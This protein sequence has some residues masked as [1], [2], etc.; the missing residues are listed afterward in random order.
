MI[1]INENTGNPQVTS[2]YVT[3]NTDYTCTLIVSDSINSKQTN[4]VITVNAGLVSY[5][6]F[7]EGL[8]STAYDSWS[9]NH[10]TLVSGPA[11][12]TD[13]NECISGTCLRFDGSNDYVKID[14]L[15][16]DLSNSF[17]FSGWFYPYSIV[18][19]Q[20]AIL[21][22]HTSAGHNLNMVFLRNTNVS[23]YDDSTK[24]VNASESISKNKWYFLTATIG[25]NGNGVLYLNGK[26]VA[27]F[28]TAV[29][30]ENGG[31]FSI[32]QEWDDATAT[33]F[34]NGLIDEVKIYSE[35]LSESQ[36]K[37]EYFTY[38]AIDNINF[39]NIKSKSADIEFNL[40]RGASTL[41]NISI[42]YATDSLF[43]NSQTINLQNQEEGFITQ[44]LTNLIPETEY[45]V[46][47]KASND[48]G[49]SKTFTSTF[50]SSP[51]ATNITVSNVLTST[52]DVVFDLNTSEVNITLEYADNIE[53]VNSTT[54]TLENQIQGKTTIPLSNLIE[55]ITY[56][57][58][59]NIVDL[60]NYTYSFQNTFTTQTINLSVSNL[61]A[62]V[63]TET[64]L[65]INSLTPEQSYTY[66]WN[67]DGLDLT[68]PDTANPTFISSI[69]DITYN[70]SLSVSDGINNKQVLFVI[71]TTTLINL[72]IDATDYAL[73]HEKTCR[74]GTPTLTNSTTT[75]Y[76]TPDSL[77]MYNKA[78]CNSYPYCGSSSYASQ[79]IHLIPGNYNLNF[80]AR[81][82]ARL[83][84]YCTS[85]GSSNKVYLNDLLLWN[86]SLAGR[87]CTWYTHEWQSVSIPFTISTEDDYDI[88]FF[89]VASDC[90]ESYFWIDDLVISIDI[91]TAEDAHIIEN[92]NIDNT[93]DQHNLFDLNNDQ[94]LDKDVG[95]NYLA[96]TELSDYL[97]SLTTINNISLIILI[98]II[99]F[100]G[101][102]KL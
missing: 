3:E 41:T 42:E 17:T 86:D 95:S 60:E 33:D 77:Q 2:P 4:F 90:A 101:F 62:T 94:S 46:R 73:T 61:T 38:R 12:I 26:S 50:A 54:V 64:T 16:A 39:K 13:E 79:T 91:N 15:A 87:G 66:L 85:Q 58:N 10:G 43:N 98:L 28:T 45:F 51:L 23:Y 29:R 102:I 84:S 81:G 1:L 99:G 49:E 97:A 88:K 68:N 5:W 25:S 78:N 6:P 30:P 37:Q 76:S 31:K 9:Q 8:G 47:I 35:A 24:Y 36:I 70:C 48:Y 27:S 11:W 59:I 53:F 55:N 40:S 83:Y 57:Y 63:D 96:S 44:S 18:T 19:A 93:S 80:Q 74:S 32:G 92:M 21:S 22:F 20:R 67:C 100:I 65:S 69:S 7:N 82:S 72:S 56:Y 52:A 89:N 14:S 34:F 71:T 75:Y